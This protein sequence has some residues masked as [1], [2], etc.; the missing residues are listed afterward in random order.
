MVE[1][2][3]DSGLWIG[4]EEAFVEELRRRSLGDGV[5]EEPD[6]GP[7]SVL[8]ENYTNSKVYGPW[9]VGGA[10][11]LQIQCLLLPII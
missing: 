7:E 11:K 3:L 1:F 5:L 6:P 10:C 8:E 9:R 2:I 4:G